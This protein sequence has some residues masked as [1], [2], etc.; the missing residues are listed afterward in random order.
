MWAP[1]DTHV[2]S[3]RF[4]SHSASSTGLALKMTFVGWLIRIN[5]V[6][7]C[8]VKV[9]HPKLPL[10]A[11]VPALSRP[12]PPPVTS[13]T[14]TC[15]LTRAGQSSLHEANSFAVVQHMLNKTSLSL[16]FTFMLTRCNYTLSF[17]LTAGVPLV[18]VELGTEPGWGRWGTCLRCQRRSQKNSEIKINNNFNTFL[19]GNQINKRQPSSANLKK[20]NEDFLLGPN[21]RI[22]FQASPGQ[23]LSF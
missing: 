8:I 23:S 2:V 10:H 11:S 18:E 21:H 3:L 16:I 15:M 13:P 19:K 12:Q 5:G 6:N 20:L 17:S 9:F 1:E 22:T 14:L 7:S 4:Y